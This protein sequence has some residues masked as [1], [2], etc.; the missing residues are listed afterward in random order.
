MNL[1]NR[2]Y[3]CVQDFQA[4]CT[5]SR[6]F[7]YLVLVLVGFSIRPECAGVTSFIR[8]VFLEPGLY[9]G[10]L[11][12]FNYST[13]L[14]LGDLT[15]IW[16]RMVHRLFPVLRVGEYDVYVADGLKVAKEGKK[17]PGVKN[18]VPRTGKTASSL[19]KQL[20]SRLHHGAFH[21]GIGFA[22]VYG[23]RPCGGGSIGFT[24]S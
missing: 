21:S 14:D 7:M 24:D 8:A 5:R 13:S 12:F 15:Q 11:H 18:E 4:A 22:G 23:G 1:W 19:R 20:E 17:M 6:T 2:W 16:C 9:K 3:H 10:F